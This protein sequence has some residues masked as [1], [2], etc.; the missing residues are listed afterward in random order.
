MTTVSLGGRWSFA[1][2]EN[3]TASHST[4]TNKTLFQF[5]LNRTSLNSSDP[6][7]WEAK[8]EAGISEF[9]VTW[10]TEFWASWGYVLRTSFK[11]RK[12]KPSGDLKPN[13]FIRSGPSQVSSTLWGKLTG[14]KKECEYSGAPVLTQGPTHQSVSRHTAPDSSQSTVVLT[15]LHSHASVPPPLNFVLVHLALPLHFPQRRE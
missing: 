10:S 8:A 1:R 15:A 14:T 2:T 5:P 9:E 13:L 11:E 7:T 12:K 6:S 4:S 3:Q